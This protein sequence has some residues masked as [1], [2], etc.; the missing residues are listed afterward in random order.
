MFPPAVVEVLVTLHSAAF[1]ASSAV[2]KPRE[3]FLL[4]PVSDRYSPSS[5]GH[6]SNGSHWSLLLVDAVNGLAFHLDSLGDCNRTAANAVHSSILK[7]IRL[8][9]NTCSAPPVPIR[10]DCLQK[11]ENGS[12]C[13][14]YVLLL[15]SLLQ[16]R[17]NTPAASSYD[18]GAVV[19][20]VCADA[21]PKHVTKF[22]KVYLKWLQAWGKATHHE[23]HVDPTRKVKVQYME[24]FSEIGVE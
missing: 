21:T 6:A 18:L 14:I 15:S 2:P 17:L 12:D 9:T 13:G 16:R 3:R 24:L 11:Q 5:P 20:T 4:L 8:S 22:R 10:V 19:E 7:L 23:E 1:D